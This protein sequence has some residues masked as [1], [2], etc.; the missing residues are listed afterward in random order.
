M[1][2]PIY[3]EHMPVKK[4]PQKGVVVPRKR[5]IADIPEPV[6]RALKVHSAQTDMEM[7]E[8]IAEALKRYLGIKEGGE[9]SKK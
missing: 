3:I 1:Y 2:Y 6:Y 8:I 4:S 5:I 7:R 9:S